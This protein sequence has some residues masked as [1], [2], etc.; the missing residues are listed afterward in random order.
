MMKRGD[1]SG[2][3]FA[4]ILVRY[5]AFVPRSGKMNHLQRSVAQER[6]RFD[7]GLIDA[8][9]ALTSAHHQ[10]R[11]DIRLQS[12]RLPRRLPIQAFEFGA[13]RRAG[14]LR[15]HFGKEGGAFSEAEQNRTHHFRR[16]PI[17]FSR[18][19]IRFM[20]KCGNPAQ[21]AGQ[22]RRRRNHLQKQPPRR[23]PPLRA[24]RPRSASVL[25]LPASAACAKPSLPQPVSG[26][27]RS[28]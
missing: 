16:E 5:Q 20:I 21:A 3:S 26:P 12:E 14:H 13:D 11:C 28:N 15:A 27:W 6:Q 22:N 2:N 10:H 23:R 1:V 8:A 24:L 17:R 9:R 25:S 18:D 4:S 19:R 7:D